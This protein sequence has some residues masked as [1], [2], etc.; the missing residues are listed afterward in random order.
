MDK[1]RPAQAG[2]GGHDTFRPTVGQLERLG[3]LTAAAALVAYGASRRSPQGAAVALAAAPL[4][5]RGL[6]GHW[7]GSSRGDTRRALGGPRG[8]HVREA[9]RVERPV[10][11]VYGFWRQVENLPRFMH[12]V[13]YVT[14]LGNGR[15]RWLAA[16][17]GGIDVQ[18]DAEVIHEVDNRLISWRSLADADVVSAGS[19]HF[20]PLN[21]GRATAVTVHMQYTPPGGR[22]GSAFAKVFGRSPEQTVREDLRRLKQILEARELAASGAHVRGGRA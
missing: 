6:S 20:D 5:F 1:S 2:S 12:Y 14:N 21:S 16:G 17:P 3:A 9:V 13:R 8:S 22:L 4:A 18:W 15:S 19:V 10:D 7:P 11:V